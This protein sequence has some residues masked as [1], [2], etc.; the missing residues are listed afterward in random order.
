MESTAHPL[1]ARPQLVVLADA[2]AMSE[3]AA[4]EIAATL[5]RLEPHADGVPALDLAVL[6]IGPEGHIASVFR[7]TPALAEPAAALAPAPLG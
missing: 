2:E 6:G 1:P 3:Q 4:K 7:D 5:G